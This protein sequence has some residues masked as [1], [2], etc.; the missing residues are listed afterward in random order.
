M[1]AVAT[2][3]LSI[4]Q[5]FFKWKRS[6]HHDVVFYAPSH[7]NRGEGAENDFFLPL[8]QACEEE[9]LSYVVLEEPTYGGKE[10]KNPFA[11]RFDA[12]LWLVIFMRKFYISKDI[13]L[14]KRDW[15]L[16][17]KLRPLFKSKTFKNVIVLSQ[18][19]MGFFKGLNPEAQIFDLQHGLIYS[20]HEGY[21]KGS[22]P[23]EYIKQCEASILLSGQGF[24]DVLEKSNYYLDKSI[25]I[26]QGEAHSVPKHRSFNRNVLVSLEFNET[27]VESGVNNKMM[28]DLNKLLSTPS[29]NQYFLRS[30]PRYRGEVP[31]DHLY[32]LDG[33][34]EAPKSLKACL[35]LC[36]L[37]YT[38]H[39]T[40]TF[41]VATVGIPTLFYYQ[42]QKD[43]YHKEFGYPHLVFELENMTDEIYQNASQSVMQWHKNYYQAFEKDTFIKALR[44]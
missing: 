16:A 12:F 9:G 31:I 19:M 30:H 33:V 4:Y 17:Q 25:V 5:Y 28:N 38:A 13:P 37:H 26:G 35:E 7:F 20:Q 1:P 29:K 22:Q 27:H 24:K 34:K 15:M 14:E 18:S 3:I 44:R 2:F 6:L 21:L 10:E 8:I 40:T 36:S 32:K 41:D 39:S 43:L 23:A 42:E 11:Y